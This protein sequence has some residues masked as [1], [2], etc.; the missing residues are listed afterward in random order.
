[1]NIWVGIVIVIVIIAIILGIYFG[2]KGSADNS[3]NDSQKDATAAA[4]ST[5]TTPT[6]V[7]TVVKAEVAKPTASKFVFEYK[8]IT[9]EEQIE[10]S[11]NGKVIFTDNAAPKTYVTKTFDLS[12]DSYPVKTIVVNF[13][14]DSGTRDVYVNKAL[15]DDVD[16]KSR[17]V[18]SNVAATDKARME[19]VAQ[20]KFL[21]PGT[22][23]Y[24]T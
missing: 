7:E 12:S 19:S 15:L 5:N 23:T 9:G 2:V 17:F 22:Y 18:A 4:L 20:G 6:P 21:W 10:I 16:I 24:T 8:G 14:N 11:V 3:K 1:M 13:K